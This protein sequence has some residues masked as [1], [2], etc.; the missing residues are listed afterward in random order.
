M[1]LIIKIMKLVSLCSLFLLV[2]SGCTNE[3]LEKN[4]DR[5]SMMAGMKEIQ[6]AIE[7]VNKDETSDGI[8]CSYKLKNTSPFLIRH[9]AAY[10]TF[11]IIREVNKNIR[12][13]TF[14]IEGLGNR[15]DIKPNEEVILQFF[16]PKEMV[17]G[18]KFIDVNQPRMELH[19]YFDE[20][21]TDNFI[22]ASFPLPK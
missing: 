1:K 11:D 2:F 12:G 4:I 17:E 13:N 22:E 15:L 8:S 3:R 10:L 20:V 7:F 9:N 5:E 6:G 21:K 18:N 14:K 19:I 16:V